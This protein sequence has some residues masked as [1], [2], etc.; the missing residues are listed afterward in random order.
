MCEVCKHTNPF[1]LVLFTGNLR[2]P[3]HSIVPPYYKSFI[4]LVAAVHFYATV[5]D[6]THNLILIL[7]LIPSYLL[8]FLLSS[9]A[10]LLSCFVICFKKND[11]INFFTN[12]VVYQYT[13]FIK[14]E[15]HTSIQ[16]WIGRRISVAAII[17]Q[18]S[19]PMP[20][21]LYHSSFIQLSLLL[22]FGD[23]SLFLL[24]PS[25]LFFSVLLH[26]SSSLLYLCL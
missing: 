6:K 7:K 10:F 4:F 25:P 22:T 17:S 19:L 14:L 11:V 16:Y 8:S 26:S 5:F 23:S 9:V 24:P 21:V 13:R 15:W 12:I 18:C 2:K 3:T 20:S 1:S